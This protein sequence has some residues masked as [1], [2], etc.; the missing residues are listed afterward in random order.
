MSY[1]FT[2]PAIRK[3]MNRLLKKLGLT[4][5]F[6]IELNT[7]VDVLTQYLNNN[8]GNPQPRLFDI[9]TEVNKELKGEIRSDKFKIR[10]KTTLFNLFYN[11]DWA[12]AQ[13]Q[14]IKNADKLIINIDVSTKYSYFLIISFS[15]T[16]FVLI[17]L[18]LTLSIAEFIKGEYKD[19]LLVLFI[20]GLPFSFGVLYPL[21]RMRWNVLNLHYDLEQ[22]L[23]KL[24]KAVKRQTELN[25]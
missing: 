5:S 13:G 6:S 16:S 14:I 17:F 22:E 2:L 20:F 3:K 15:I 7:S 11:W 1:I 19:G 8:I 4:D 12:V 10:R 24:R 25:N 21:W 23:N 18:G 9:F